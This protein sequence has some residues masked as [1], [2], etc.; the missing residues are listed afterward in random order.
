MAGEN[1]T[2]LAPT[3]KVSAAGVGGSAGIVLVWVLGQLG[4]DMPVEVAGAVVALLAFGA[5]Y[6]VPSRDS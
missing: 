5:G 1:T 6:L 3:R 2:D 4:I